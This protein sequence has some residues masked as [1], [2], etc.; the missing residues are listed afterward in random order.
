MLLSLLS[1]LLLCVCVL[2]FVVCCVSF[3]NTFVFSKDLNLPYLFYLIHNYQ[4]FIV[5]IS[6]H[7]PKNIIATI[8]Y[9]YIAIIL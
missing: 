5:K 3:F 1:V 9:K 6:H 2:F 7:L 8:L 4:I